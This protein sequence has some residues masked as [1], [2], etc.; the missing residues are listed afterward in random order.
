MSVFKVETFYRKI[1]C[2]CVYLIQYTFINGY[3]KDSIE[4]HLICSNCIKNEKENK[5]SYETKENKKIE[6]L[7]NEIIEDDSNWCSANG[8]YI[9]SL[10]S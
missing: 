1:E 5:V 8:N 6:E 4:K 3:D 7:Y 10:Y 2:G 9:L